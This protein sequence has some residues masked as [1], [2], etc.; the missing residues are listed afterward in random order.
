MG[1]F[2]P[3]VDRRRVAAIIRLGHYL[4]SSVAQQPR[5]G[6]VCRVVVDEDDLGAEVAERGIQGRQQSVQ[7]G[8]C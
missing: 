4:H 3:D 8:R 1:S 6:V 7:V 2:G 5:N